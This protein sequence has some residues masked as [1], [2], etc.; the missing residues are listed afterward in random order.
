MHSPAFHNGFGCYSASRGV[1]C[2]A[3]TRICAGFVVRASAISALEE[4]NPKKAQYEQRSDDVLG[5]IA[6]GKLPRHPGQAHAWRL[7]APWPRPHLAAAKLVELRSSV[8]LVAMPHEPLDRPVASL[9]N[10][11]VARRSLR[12]HRS[13]PGYLGVAAL[14][15]PRREV[16]RRRHHP[17]CA[18]FATLT[19]LHPWAVLGSPRCGCRGLDQRRRSGVGAGDEAIARGPAKSAA[20]GDVFADVPHRFWMLQCEPWRGPLRRDPKL[21]RVCCTSQFNRCPRSGQQRGR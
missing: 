6:Q 7:C 15:L 21:C 11:R 19:S 16:K 8:N 18:T 2:Y 9:T 4:G 10:P 3:V 17:S 5:E 1:A 14:R 13:T 20:R 12:S